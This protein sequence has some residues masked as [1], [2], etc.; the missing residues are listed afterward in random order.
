M[1]EG[2]PKAHAHYPLGSFE[3]EFEF[4]D[5]YFAHDHTQQA[6]QQNRRKCPRY[7]MARSDGNVSGHNTGHAGF[8]D[9]EYLVGSEKDGGALLVWSSRNIREM[10][11]NGHSD[12]AIKIR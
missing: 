7:H 8:M 5:A 10:H 4:M 9:L 11:D 2:D 12:L 1:Q 6:I 3:R